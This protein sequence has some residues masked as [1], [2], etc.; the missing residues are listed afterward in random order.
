MGLSS[1]LTQT[2]H[3]EG[4]VQFCIKHKVGGGLVI[5][6]VSGP[7]Y[8]EVGS[9]QRPASE[10]GS[11]QTL[12]AVNMGTA[13]PRSPGF[14]DLIGSSPARW[15]VMFE[16][17]PHAHENRHR[18]RTQKVF[19]LWEPSEIASWVHWEVHS[20]GAGG[21]R[22]TASRPTH[23]SA[24]TSVSGCGGSRHGRDQS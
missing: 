13:D 23:L 15:M 5:T 17:Q 20:Q 1:S 16:P 3:T 12:I 22:L 9:G 19:Q 18:H 4:E 2:R 7:I 14:H 11:W 6:V 21:R 8:R 10:W 24:G